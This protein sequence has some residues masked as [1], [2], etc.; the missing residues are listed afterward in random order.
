MLRRGMST[1]TSTS[2]RVFHG[3][4]LFGRLATKTARSLVNI[5]LT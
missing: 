3:Q 1:C 5:I 2:L 4:S